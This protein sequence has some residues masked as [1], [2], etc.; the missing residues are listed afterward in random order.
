[1]LRFFAFLLIII[2]T[3]GLGYFAFPKLYNS[4][5]NSH[6]LSP[7]NWP[8]TEDPLNNQDKP[9]ESTNS[10]NVENDTQPVEVNLKPLPTQKILSNDYHVF[11]SFNNCGPAALSMALSYYGINKSQQELG[12]ALRPY[13]NPQGDN[14]DK[15]VTLE[16][17]ALKGE[18]LGFVAY[19]RP[20]G[21]FEL[22]SQFINNDMPVITRTWLKP[23]EDIGHYRVVKGFNNTNR[24]FL[25]DDSLQGANLVYTIEE[26]DSI[27]KQFGYEYLVLVPK[28]KNDIAQQILG[29]NVDIDV[30]WEKSLE[31][32]QTQVQQN[33]TDT[34]SRL[35]LSVA[36]Y[37]NGQY[38]ESVKEFE[39]VEN[40]ISF[41][42]LW[43][44]IEPIL[45]YVE[46]QQYYKVFDITDSILNNHNRAFSELYLIRG[47]IYKKQG[48]TQAAKSEFEKAVLY[49]VNMK[50]AHG[51]LNSL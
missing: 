45:A 48:N 46:L 27:W 4:Y 44:Q 31:Y 3:L 17:L 2:G 39:A 15:S 18:E 16:E 14:D 43:Y 51:A 41:R 49:N 32:W 1:M 12:N 5:V 50:K 36:Y 37:M 9:N 29:E 21:N 11:Q 25:Q 42:T 40:D 38:D 13:Q 34:H 19:H 23:N 6:K 24:T 33:P 20:N 30:A 47:E 10:E 26:F 7:N 28:E 22:L 8:V 35:N